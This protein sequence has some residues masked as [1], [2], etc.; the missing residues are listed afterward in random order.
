MASSMGMVFASR[1]G[2]GRVV[3]LEVEATWIAAPVLSMATERGERGVCPSSCSVG[4]VVVT[5][6]SLLKKGRDSLQFQFVSVLF[7]LS[8]SSLL[9]SFVST[10]TTLCSGSRRRR[11]RHSERFRFSF[12][13]S[14]SLFFF[15]FFFEVFFFLIAKQ[16]FL[17]VRKINV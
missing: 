16:H 5:F 1:G 6:R 8:L 11:R 13:L 7:P 17:L 10:C 4:G 3:A 2:E 9:P 14:L 15:F 12:S